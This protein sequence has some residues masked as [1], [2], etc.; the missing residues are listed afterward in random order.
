M[1]AMRAL[2]LR[3]SVRIEPLKPASEV[4][5]VPMVPIVVFLLAVSGY[6]HRGLFREIEGRHPLS[7][8][9]SSNKEDRRKN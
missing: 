7:H 8:P 5:K 9:F 1:L 4:V 3:A 2:T 6:A